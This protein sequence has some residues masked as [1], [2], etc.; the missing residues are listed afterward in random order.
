MVWIRLFPIL[1]FPSNSAAAVGS[2][3]GLLLQPLSYI[4]GATWPIKLFECVETNIDTNKAPG[5]SCFAF[6]SKISRKGF[7]MDLCVLLLQHHKWYIQL[8]LRTMCTPMVPWSRKKLPPSTHLSTIPSFAS[9]YRSTKCITSLTEV[10]K[11]FQPLCRVIIRYRLRSV[12]LLG[13]RTF[14][15]QLPGPKV[16]HS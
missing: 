14:F 9:V 13:L 2:A 15:K 12:L 11:N 7:E 8:F 1:N 10:I 6:K 4:S 16:P 3:H 5:F